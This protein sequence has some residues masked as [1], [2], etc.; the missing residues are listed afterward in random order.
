[1]RRNYLHRQCPGVE[2]SQLQNELLTYQLDVANLMTVL[3]A[4]FSDRA[5]E[6]PTSSSLS[7]SSVTRPWPLRQSRHYE[8]LNLSARSLSEG[9]GQAGSVTGRRTWLL[10]PACVI[11]LHRLADEEWKSIY[12]GQLVGLKPP[13]GGSCKTGNRVDLEA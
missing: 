11:F 13:G 8:A 10:G 12:R 3:V 9:P 2:N 5:T 6:V 4:G 1:M 7:S